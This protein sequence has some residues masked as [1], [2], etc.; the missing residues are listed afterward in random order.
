MIG[1]L[2]ASLNLAFGHSVIT[3]LSISYSY[4]YIVWAPLRLGKSMP[5]EFHLP[6]LI[7]AAS[8]STDAEKCNLP[9][10]GINMS[11]EVCTFYDPEFRAECPTVYVLYKKINC[12]SAQVH[13]RTGDVPS[14]YNPDE[15]QIQSPKTCAKLK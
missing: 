8:N 4:H 6:T 14:L 9:D 15:G 2:S 1:N 3:Q 5:C 7:L 11:C 10:Q 12:H 13:V